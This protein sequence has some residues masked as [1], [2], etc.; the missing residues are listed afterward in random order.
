[1]RI[2]GPGHSP[3]KL[4]RSAYRRHVRL[5]RL[6]GGVLGLGG[7][8]TA[9][10][11]IVALLWIQSRMVF[12]IAAAHGYD[13]RHPMRPAELLALL[14]V[15]R[16]PA[17]ARRALDGI[18]KHLAVAVVQ[19]TISGRPMDRLHRRLARYLLQRLARHYGG[20]MIPIIGAPLGAMQNA[21]STKDLGRLALRYYGGR[22]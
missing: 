2:A 10:P 4:A 7:V 12:Y 9:A 16:T 11:D 5:A 20:K 14:G 13:P 1:V 19:R 17:D 22:G 21:G 15:Y 18:G 8:F 3:K 6:E